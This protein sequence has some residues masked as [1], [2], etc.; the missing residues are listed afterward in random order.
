M[1]NPASNEKIQRDVRWVYLIKCN[2]G[3]FYT[4]ST[5]DPLKRLKQHLA[6]KGAKF[7][8]RERKRPFRMFI[9][10]EFWNMKQCGEFE[11]KVKTYSSSDKNNLLEGA[12]EVL[13]GLKSS[14]GKE[15]R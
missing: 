1:A 8:N 4:G 12:D 2:D 7:L 13:A 11:K 14:S 15:E 10:E 6:G 9:I 5:F 3:S